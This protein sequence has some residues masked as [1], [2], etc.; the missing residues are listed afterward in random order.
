MKRLADNQ[1]RYCGK[2]HDEVAQYVDQAE[3]WA[4]TAVQCECGHSW[5]MIYTSPSNLASLRTWLNRGCQ[6][7]EGPV[8][9]VRGT[10]WHAYRLEGIR[11]DLVDQA[12]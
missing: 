3:R 11:P 1:C 9:V 4:M 12:S 8:A 5:T 6:P 2:V 10:P 7:A